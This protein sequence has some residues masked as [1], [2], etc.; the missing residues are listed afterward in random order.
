MTKIN[1]SFIDLIKNIIIKDKNIGKYYSIKYPNSKYK[2]DEL[3]KS[4]FYILKTGISWRDL[5]TTIK[6][7]SIY[8][9]FTRFVKF[10][11]FK[12]CFLK[13]RSLFI[14]KNKTNIQIIDSTFIL[15]KY[16]K[17]FIA[18]NVFFK[19]KNCNKVSLITDING[20][21]ISAIIKTGNVHDQS[22]IDEHLKDLYYLNKKYNSKMIIL[23]DKGYESK[24]TRNKISPK[25]SL[26]IPKKI[27]MKITYDFDKNLYK[28]RIHV[29]HCFQRLKVFRRIMIRYDS[30]VRNYLSFL[31]LALSQLI[32]KK[33]DTC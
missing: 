21:P 27:N 17:N 31:Y 14:S 28:N 3:I 12:K 16:G 10:D 33:I 1:I 20:I 19:S 29:E 6:W 26:M 25:Y 8:Y 22:F 5:K 18:R 24:S 7:Q 23:A 13:L 4:I 11:I 32:F 2:L 15:N 9:H 30:L